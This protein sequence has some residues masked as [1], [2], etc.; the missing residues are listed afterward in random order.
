MNKVVFNIEK[1]IISSSDDPDDDLVYKRTSFVLPSIKSGITNHCTIPWNHVTIDHKGRIFICQCDGWV[2]FSVGHVTDFSSLDEIFNSEQAIKI[3]KSITNK[4]YEYCAV[5]QCGIRNSN[6]SED[7]R[8]NINIDISCNLSCPSCR[9]HIIFVKD[10]EIISE[11][12]K[13]IDIIVGWI[14]KI[15]KTVTV[16]CQGGEP[17]ASLL[18]STVIEDLAKLPN[19]KFQIITNGTLLKSRSDLVEKIINK[20]DF[21]RVSIDGASKD[22]YETVRRGASWDL[23]LENLNYLK[24]LGKR[25]YGMFVIQKHNIEDILPFVEFCEIYNLTPGYS[26]LQ[27][28][29]TW[30][31]FTD[32]CVHRRDSVLYD[33]FKEITQILKNKKVSISFLKEWV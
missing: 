32:H 22:V 26:V 21:F 5:D 27:D 15:P 11:K 17:F 2:P 13:W 20:T 18:Y 23:L 3:Q 10:A 1:N 25:H 8:I 30:H 28:W 12:M 6:L 4:E 19:T 7:I 9:E 24:T 31:N 29:G 33:R 16:G 14:E